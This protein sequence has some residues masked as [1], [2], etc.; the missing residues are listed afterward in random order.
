[1]TSSRNARKLP[2]LLLGTLVLGAVSMPSCP[3]KR[4]STPTYFPHE[5][6]C[7]LFYECGPNGISKLLECSEGLDFNPVLHV[8]D[9]PER[10]GCRNRTSTTTVIPTSRLTRK[11]DNSTTSPPAPITNPPT[12]SA[13]IILLSNILEPF[14]RSVVCPPNRSSEST[15]I[16]HESNCSL[17]YEC[18]PNGKP[19]LQKCAKGL[20][21]NPVLHVCDYPDQ[22]GC[23]NRTSTTTGPR[24]KSPAVDMP[25]IPPRPM[26]TVVKKFDCGFG[27]Q[28]CISVKRRMVAMETEQY[29]P[30]FLPEKIIAWLQDKE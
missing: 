5:T 20:D 26:P 30:V 23:R 11:P 12:R 9:Y 21:F 7:S 22:A 1:M 29:R 25:T 17:F 13:P 16:P 2:F 8:C 6:N 14:L 18:G 19:K 28:E 3:P 24:T 4:T 10:A 27:R 15:Y